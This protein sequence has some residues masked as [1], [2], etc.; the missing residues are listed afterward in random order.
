MT[1]YDN[2]VL[3][4]CAFVLAGVAF[5]SLGAF[6]AHMFMFRGGTSLWTILIFG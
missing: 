6:I 5:M 3:F 2:W 4:L 1:K